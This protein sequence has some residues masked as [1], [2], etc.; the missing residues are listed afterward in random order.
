[1]R[2]WLLRVA[3]LITGLVIISLFLA[4][5]L[6][7]GS[8]P[9][10]DGTVSLSGIAQAVSI[11]RD[12]AGIP[13]IRAANRRDLAFATGYVHG[14]DRFFQMDLSRRSAAGELAALVGVVALDRDKRVRIHR[15]RV[16]AGQ[17]LTDMDPG[18]RDILEAYADGVNAALDAMSTRPFEYIVLREK[19]APWQAEDCL[20]VLYAMFLDLNDAGADRDIEMSLVADAVPAAVFAWLY[21]T[22]SRWD[23]P[24]T[25][26][27][28]AE[29]PVP[30]PELYD[31]RDFRSVQF[32]RQEYLPEHLPGSNNW[33]VS[34]QITRDGRAIVANDMHLGLRVPNIFYRARF[35]V[36]AA[37]SVDIS[38]VTLPG[39]PAMVVG[40]NGRIAWGFTNSYGDWSDAIVVR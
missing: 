39:T 11:Q 27:A 40:S 23:A 7:R 21:P 38:G 2:R 6:L 18:Q 26:E 36:H 29:V 12:G 34:G 13:V 33:A 10:L 20:L 9:I 30:G 8:L 37:D 15:F 22:G 31:L 35:L 17:V 19:P 16:R 4:W 25:G 5:Q 32:A 24:L 3:G 14:Q 28:S 1:M